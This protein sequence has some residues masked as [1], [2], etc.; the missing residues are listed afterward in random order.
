M[1]LFPPSEGRRCPPVHALSPTDPRQ[2]GRYRL[3]ARL[4]GGGM[5][6]VFLGR[7]PGG[8]AVA[9]KVIRPELAR[10]P[11]FRRRFAAEVEAA[12]RVGGF[13]TAQIVA[14]DP[15][16]DPPWLVT[17][18]IS[19][20]SLAEVL[21]GH[22][23]L[24]E[25]SLVALGAG[26]AEA[27]EAVHAAGIVHR[28]LK[29]SNI[30][31]LD[32]GPRVIDFGI[33]RALDATALTRPGAAP[34]TPGFMAPEQ[35]ARGEVETAADVFALGM[36]L[37][38]AAGVRPFGEGATHALLYR[39]VHEE[40]RLDGVP[41]ALRDVL[42]A[43]LAK[44]PE[45]R[46]TPGDLLDRF[47]GADPGDGWLPDGP[48]REMVTLRDTPPPPSQSQPQATPAPEW[49]RFTGIKAKLAAGILFDLLCLPVALFILVGAV[50][51]MGDEGSSVLTLGI[52]LLLGAGSL[53]L[54]RDAYLRLRALSRPYELFIG[55][56]GI[57]LRYGGQDTGYGW[58]EI[59]RVALRRS[60]GHLALAVLPAPEVPRP[61]YRNP[62]FRP[63]LE[64]AG[65][66]DEPWIVLSRLADLHT[67][68]EPLEQALSRYARRWSPER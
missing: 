10:D 62:V 7:S 66:D 27:L 15:H 5:G 53:W 33:A 47:A 16:A 9:V 17:A 54:G 43:C 37:C 41:E 12:R 36:V 51:S 48:I 50:A 6:E 1:R 61:R 20:P 60:G 42:R 39:V 59:R 19:G 68:R 24:P 25:R 34:G 38:H 35:I 29:P 13:H 14:A 44:R 21:A 30:L 56:N 57:R 8:R 2:V 65:V 11:E 26:L 55:T 49:A 46:P 63:Y 23:A 22:G 58:W 18:Y 67:G 40:P 32:D 4:G 45:D 31:L 52:I 64:R 28:D 3:E